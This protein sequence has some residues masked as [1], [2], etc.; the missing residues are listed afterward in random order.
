MTDK[1]GQIRL[2]AKKK[3]NEENI[4]PAE[5]KKMERENEENIW[6]RKI[7]IFLLGEILNHEFGPGLKLKLVLFIQKI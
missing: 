5:E 2:L 7:N 1:P 6:R 4:W 3:E